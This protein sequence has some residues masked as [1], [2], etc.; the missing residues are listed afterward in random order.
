MKVIARMAIRAIGAWPMKILRSWSGRGF[1][2]EDSERH[3][4]QPTASAS[5]PPFGGLR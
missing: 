4:R 1:G 2:E 5:I 3:H